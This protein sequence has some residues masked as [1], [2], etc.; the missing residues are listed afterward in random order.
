M[1]GHDSH[2]YSFIEA[3]EIVSCSESTLRRRLNENGSKLGATRLKKGWR[4]PVTTLEAMGVLKP[5]TSHATDHLTGHD[6]AESDQEMSR[7]RVENATLRAE[8]EGL[9]RLLSEREKVVALLE[10]RPAKREPF[11][12]RW[13]HGGEDTAS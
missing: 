8:N 9:R 13:G 3:L 10:Q 12:K 2:E 5:V 4:I 11:W 7:L 1:T 6:R